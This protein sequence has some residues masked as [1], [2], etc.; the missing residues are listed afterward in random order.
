M[1]MQR[2][3]FRNRM[4]HAAILFLMAMENKRFPFS[5]FVGSIHTTN[6]L[7]YFASTNVSMH[8]WKDIFC[9][10][11]DVRFN[12]K[13]R[14]VMESW[15]T[16]HLFRVLFKT[17]FINHSKSVF[18]FVV[19]IFRSSQGGCTSKNYNP[20]YDEIKPALRFFLVLFTLRSFTTTSS[21]LEIP[22]LSIICIRTTVFNFI[23]TMFRLCCPCLSIRVT[24]R[25]F[26]T[27]NLRLINGVKYYRYADHKSY[28]SVIAR[29]NLWL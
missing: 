21:F 27:E 1:Q 28:C 9:T 26:Q 12:Y 8:G 18:Y 19:Y 4:K 13:R 16:K 29:L 11:N 24:L 22:A 25:E 14:F 15:K 5:S 6:I 20:L 10:G 17:N 3:Y 23:I 7:G 2:K